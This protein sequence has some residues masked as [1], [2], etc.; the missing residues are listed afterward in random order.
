MGRIYWLFVLSA[1][2]AISLTGCGGNKPSGSEDVERGRPGGNNTSG[3]SRN[4]LLAQSQENVRQLLVGMRM[5]AND[6]DD[7]LPLNNRWMDGI[8]PYVQSK[9]A[10]WSPAVDDGTRGRYGYAMNSG[11]VGRPLSLFPNPQN[12]FAIFDSTVLRRNATASPNTRPVPGR[13]EGTNTEGMLSGT[14]RNEVKGSANDKPDKYPEAKQR[15]SNIA[16]AM[17]LYAQDWD[18]T[19][20]PGPGWDELIVP[21]L[22]DR[23]RLKSPI[24]DGTPNFG[25]AYNSEIAGLPLT[26]IPSPTSTL[27]VFDSTQLTKGAVAPPSTLPVPGRYAGK[28]AQVMVD[29]TVLP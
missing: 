13:Y 24:F 5:Y 20:P 10:F 12:I 26:S 2:A 16:A 23:S 18:D 6:N 17:L 3:G 28:N 15:L 22:K 27:L 29:G 9:S 21:Y 19:L 7:V 14:I 8:R 11:I 25:F 1:A 4:S